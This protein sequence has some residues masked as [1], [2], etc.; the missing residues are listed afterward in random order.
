MSADNRDA[1]R[2]FEKNPILKKV[3]LQGVDEGI[4][5]LPVHDGIAVPSDH[6]DWA[7]KAFGGR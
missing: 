5:C 7:Q 1:T 3:M 2:S 6:L 4:C